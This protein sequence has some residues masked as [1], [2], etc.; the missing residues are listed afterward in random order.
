ML[1]ANYSSSYWLNIFGYSRS[2]YFKE[3]KLS[4]FSDLGRLSEEK[5]ADLLSLWVNKVS[6]L[7]TGWSI[8]VLLL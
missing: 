6:I 7:Y 2:F 3:K 4:L 5:R 1:A 8:A